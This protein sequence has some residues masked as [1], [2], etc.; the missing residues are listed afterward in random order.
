MA[1]F[2]RLIPT[3]AVLPGVIK[4]E[5]YAVL[6]L[7]PMVIYMSVAST[8]QYMRSLKKIK[9]VC[10]ILS[11]LI[12]TL[13]RIGPPRPCIVGAG[14][15]VDVGMGPLWLPVRACCLLIIILSACSPNPFSQSA[16]VHKTPTPAMA[17]GEPVLPHSPIHFHDAPVPAD[18]SFYGGDW[19]LAG[20]GRSPTPSLNTSSIL[21]HSA[22]P[23]VWV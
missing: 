8:G 1:T 5:K 13:R 22:P 9:I 10:G 12:P 20:P 18:L 11:L 15:D 21:S 3:A 17:G 7:W 6:P 19:T 14:E 23:S 16:V 2:M 4:R